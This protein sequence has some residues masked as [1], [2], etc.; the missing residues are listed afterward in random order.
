MSGERFGH[1]TTS[2]LNTLATRRQG[3]P[4]ARRSD[5]VMIS[6]LGRRLA[7]VRIRSPVNPVSENPH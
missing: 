4:V 3:V 5:C 1:T 7:F 6:G 2:I